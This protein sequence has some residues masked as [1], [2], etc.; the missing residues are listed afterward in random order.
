MRFSDAIVI[1]GL[2]TSK[3]G[4]ETVYR[5]LRDGGVTAI[6]ATIAIWDDYESTLHMITKYLEW[7]DEFDDLIRP[8]KTITDIHKAK[9][10]N[11]TGII[12]GWQNA[13]P[14]GNDLTRLKLFHELGVRVIQLTYNE[15][16]LLGNG[17]YE[18]TDDGLS[19][20]GLAAVKEM[21]RLGILIDLSHVGDRTTLDAIENSAQPVAITHANA[22]SHINHPRSKTDEAIK[23]LVERGGVIGANGFPMFFEK[24]FET[25]LD[26]YI[27]AIDYLVQMVGIDHVGIGTDFCTEQPRSFF[28]WI[29][30]SQGNIPAKEVAYTPEPYTHLKGFESQAE[31]ANVVERLL[32]RNYSEADTRKVLGENWLKLFGQVWTN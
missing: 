17:C 11:R 31:W 7:F 16:N 6:N 18:R 3:W 10:E 25:G 28:D 12:F 4:R 21:N 24:G 23:L 19:N 13:S 27:D 32:A 26:E 15:R 9:A 2:D 22:R 29:F 14:I 20:F 30:S 5:E 1:D 8:V